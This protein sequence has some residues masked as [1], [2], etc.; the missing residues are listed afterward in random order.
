MEHRESDETDKVASSEALRAERNLRQL[1]GVQEILTALMVIAT[2]CSAIATWE[3]TR[4]V[5]RGERPYV[6]IES[7]RLTRDNTNR[8]YVEIKYENFGNVASNRTKLEAWAMIDGKLASFD[9]MRPEVRQILLKLGILSPLAPHLFAAY[10]RP[11]A[12]DAIRDGKSELRVAI[13]F[14]YRGPAG[15][16]YCYKMIFRYFAPAGI[17]DPSGGTDNCRSELTAAAPPDD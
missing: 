9:P 15:E 17:F 13:T 1:V 16:P 3:A 12:L 6:G 11:E 7:V 2:L 14:Q 4:V 8:P 5:A 10:F